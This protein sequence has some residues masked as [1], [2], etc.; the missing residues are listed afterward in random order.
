MPSSRPPHPVL[1]VD[2]DERTLTIGFPGNANGLRFTDDG[3]HVSA[4]LT[5]ATGRISADVSLQPGSVVR[6]VDQAAR[7]SDVDP[8]RWRLA[9]LAAVHSW[10]DRL[11]WCPHDAS[12]LVTAVGALTHPLLGPVYREGR[13]P[14]GE[15]PRWAAPLLRHLDVADAARALVDHSATRRVTRS[16]AASLLEGPEGHVGLGPL[17]LA[18]IGQGHLSSDQAANLLD[19]RMPGHPG[20][21]PT[22]DDVRLCRDG[23][24]LYPPARVP[25]LLMDVAL[26][27]D[28]KALATAMTQ[29]WWV[30]D[31]LDH[32]LPVRL[33]DV[34]ELCGRLVPVLA[35]AA[36]SPPADTTPR[37][38]AA[39]ARP[40]RTATTP[41][42][43]VAATRA[44]VTAAPRRH[45]MPM[46]A[47][48]TAA[49]GAA[50]QRWPVPSALMGVHQQRHDDLHFTVPTSQPE[51]ASWGRRLHNCLDT[52][53]RAM[54]EER[55]WLIGVEHDDQLVGCIE[56]APTT[57]SV[58]QALGPRNR[59]LPPWVHERALQFLLAM[60][61]I[62]TT[63]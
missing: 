62:R 22:V 16:L 23:L 21:W 48:H 25:T 45:A 41:A 5:F 3:D 18:V 10:T 59:P 4:H 35:P 13:Q 39:V 8:N 32:T 28:A 61:V 7:E 53:A 63:T 49:R 57:R 1:T 12:R 60:G 27:H 9:V 50:P 29:L 46:T 26:H 19:V 42:P 40:P 37:P 24:R 38:A 58:R 31:R 33:D 44:A 51:L 36:T 54:V 2:A 15:I 52:Y 56:V 11:S 17:G 34:R 14:L 43:T 30:R 47:P 6:Q 20:T 55:S